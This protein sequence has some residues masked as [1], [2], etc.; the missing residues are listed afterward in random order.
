[1][2]P[3]V[4]VIA[5]AA[6]ST[7]EAAVAAESATATGRR[8]RRPAVCAEAKTI[9]SGAVLDAIE[10]VDEDEVEAVRQYVIKRANEDKAME[11]ERAKTRVA[12]R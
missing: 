4:A 6:E 9:R 11:A 7:V 1:M 3:K 10:A 12:R 5:R 8:R 2:R